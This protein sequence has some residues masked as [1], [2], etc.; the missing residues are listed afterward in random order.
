[1]IVV[2]LAMLVLLFYCL[3]DFLFAY[4]PLLCS[5]NR[6]CEILSTGLARHV[7]AA[8]KQDVQQNITIL[9]IMMNDED[10]DD[11]DT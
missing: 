11:D 10:N 1:M 9:I 6:P 2:L 3:I 5:E 4:S 7:Q 8:K